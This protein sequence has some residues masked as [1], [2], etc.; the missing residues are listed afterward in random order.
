MNWHSTYILLVG[1]IG[2]ILE[3]MEKYD[4]WSE[5]MDK[6]QIIMKIIQKY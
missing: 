6:E 5:N 2:A 3:S 1:D 4:E